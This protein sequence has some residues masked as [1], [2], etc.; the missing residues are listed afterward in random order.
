MG[1]KEVLK[2]KRESFLTSKGRSHQRWGML[3]SVIKI[4]GELI[5]NLLVLPTENIVHLKSDGL[6]L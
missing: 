6:L 4:K 5:N 2:R 1:C 3:K